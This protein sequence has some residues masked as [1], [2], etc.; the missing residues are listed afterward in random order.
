[1]QARFHHNIAHKAELRSLYAFHLVATLET[2]GFG[3]A[4]NEGMKL[5]NMFLT[6]QASSNTSSSYTLFNHEDGAL[7][8]HWRWH[9][10][11]FK[12]WKIAWVIE[13][14]ATFYVIASIELSWIEHTLDGV[15]G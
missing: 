5:K 12:I 10:M 8:G 15:W 11:A 9:M 3:G 4:W 1:M 6:P 2:W 7:E 13:E 14:D